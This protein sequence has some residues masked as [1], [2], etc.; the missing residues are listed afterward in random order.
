MVKLVSLG[1]RKKISQISICFAKL[2]RYCNKSGIKC[3]NVTCK[4]LEL[5]VYFGHFCL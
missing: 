4:C 5:E 3:Y 2:P 1:L